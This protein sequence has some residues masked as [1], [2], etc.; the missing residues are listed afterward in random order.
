M[1]KKTTLTGLQKRGIASFITKLGKGNGYKFFKH[2]IIK[3]NQA[4]NFKKDFGF[5]ELDFVELVM[6]CE[7]KLNISLPDD[8]LNNVK[9]L[10]QFFKLVENQL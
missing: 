9:T 10:N 5:D 4:Y 1:A 7:K 2:N 3:L 8:K 6:F